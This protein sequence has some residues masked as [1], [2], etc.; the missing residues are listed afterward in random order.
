MG[1]WFRGFVPI[2][3]HPMSLSRDGIISLGS[4]LPP[5]LGIF[6][7]L[8]TLLE[9]PSPPPVETQPSHIVRV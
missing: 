9:W 5:A 3:G 7:R 8:R 6:G 4:K 1:L 2:K